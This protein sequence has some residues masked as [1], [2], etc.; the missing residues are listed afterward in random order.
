MSFVF[1]LNRICFLSQKNENKK[2]KTGQNYSIKKC[3]IFLKKTIDKPQKLWYTVQAVRESG[4]T[5]REQEIFLRKL[6]KV[7]DK[8]RT[9]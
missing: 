3:W 6:K 5:P 7:L 8:E 1:C 4:V 2:E 9:V